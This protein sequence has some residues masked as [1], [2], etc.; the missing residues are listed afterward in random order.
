MA[1]SAVVILDPLGNRL[2]NE[3]DRVLVLVL[4]R[5]VVVFEHARLLKQTLDL[6]VVPARLGDGLRFRVFDREGHTEIVF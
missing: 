6:V 3:K 2:S 4:V 1:R 5:H